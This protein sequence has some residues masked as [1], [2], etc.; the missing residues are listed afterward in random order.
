MKQLADQSW[1]LR[2]AFLADAARPMPWDLQIARA[3]E[4]PTAAST[5]F[6]AATGGPRAAPFH[7]HAFLSGGVRWILLDLRAVTDR[8]LAAVALAAKLYQADHAGR[9]PPTLDALVPSCLPAVPT[10][11]FDPAGGPIRYA[12]AFRPGPTAAPSPRVYSVGED[13]LDAG[14][15]GTPTKRWTASADAPFELPPPPAT[16]PLRPAH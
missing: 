16:R 11:P 12:P 15:A 4:R 14:G 3:A 9:L 5:S 13:G 8:R 2:P 7:F 6:L 10:D 1:L